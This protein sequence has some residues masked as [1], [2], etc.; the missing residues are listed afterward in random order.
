MNPGLS[1][2]LNLSVAQLVNALECLVTDYYK[3]NDIELPK[4]TK[5]G[6]G[7]HANNK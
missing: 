3:R 1:T 5:G 6:R 7:A 4:T 2:K